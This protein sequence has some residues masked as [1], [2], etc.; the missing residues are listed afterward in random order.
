MQVPVEE[1]ARP[2]ATLAV[3][4]AQVLDEWEEREEAEIQAQTEVP[5][6]ERAALV[7]ARRGQGIFRENV[8]KVERAC[9]ITGVAVPNFLVA[10]HI[11]PWRHS[12]NQERLDGHNGLLL[13]PSRRAPPCPRSADVG[14]AQCSSGV[15]ERGDTRCS[16]RGR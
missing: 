10:S 12:S 8:S 4:E 16:L 1:L 11:K 7:K 14:R 15:A 9:R 5:E 2:A 6:T 13:S 3:R